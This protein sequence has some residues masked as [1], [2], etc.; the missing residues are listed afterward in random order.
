M[1]KFFVGQRVRLA[2]KSSFATSLAPIGVTGVI[3]AIGP[4]MPGHYFEG[5]IFTDETDCL[6]VWDYSAETCGCIFPQ[7]EPI[8]PE[9]HRP[10]DESFKREL[11]KLLEA[12]A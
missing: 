8:L 2:W 5:C 11:D 6:V 3:K 4:R 12:I 1:S 7:L 10:C 9:G